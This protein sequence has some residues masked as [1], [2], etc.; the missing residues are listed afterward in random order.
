MATM[1]SSRLCLGL[2][3]GSPFSGQAMQQPT[4]FSAQQQAELELLKLYITEGNTTFFAM[5]RQELEAEGGYRT[6]PEKMYTLAQ[7]YLSEGD[8]DNHKIWCYQAA[9]AGHMEAQYDLGECYE[10]G[11]EPFTQSD[12]EAVKW[13]T[14]AAENGHIKA[15]RDLETLKTEIKLH[16][17]RLET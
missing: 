15:Q 3:L 17:A 11:D 12:T 6:D 5:K 7:I 8:D 14:K 9:E 16:P 2:C 4:E 10:M 13:Y 1:L